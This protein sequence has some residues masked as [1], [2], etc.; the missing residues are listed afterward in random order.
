MQVFT[1]I[2]KADREKVRDAYKDFLTELASWYYSDYDA[3]DIE[4]WWKFEEIV[5]DTARY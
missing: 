4:D 5:L 1:D 2:P 3:W